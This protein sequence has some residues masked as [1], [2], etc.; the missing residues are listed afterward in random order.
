MTLAPGICMEN[1]SLS[2]GSRPILQ[3]LSLEMAG[4]QWHSLLGRS[5]VGKSSLLRLLSELWRPD[6]GRLISDAGQS[7]TGQVAHLSQE[8][9]L[10]PWLSVL[11]NVQLGPRL[12]GNQ[13]TQV[14]QRALA[15]LDRVG[16]ADWANSLP[17][18]LSG[19]MRQRVALAR[20]L[21][22]DRPIVLMDEPFSHLDA[23]TR[24]DLQSL[25]HDLLGERTV[26]LVTHDPMEA[27]RLSDTIH[28]LQA[29]S[30]TRCD[31]LTP[32]NK[33][34]RPIDSTA[35]ITQTQRLWQM[36]RDPR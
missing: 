31:L 23:I 10:L 2:L 34:P 18:R 27:L 4:A 17:N 14:R 8:D 36:L 20:T 13:S 25:S 28:V 22:E 15:L 1:V 19:G 3:N 30:P 21:L 9:A 35:V 26:V 6:T 32:E 24:D 29:G 12:R 33:P 5:G 7:L 16:L 11:D